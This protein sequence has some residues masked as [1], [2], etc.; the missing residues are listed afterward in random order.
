MLDSI[1]NIENWWNSTDQELIQLKKEMIERVF[2]KVKEKN[3]DDIFL[4]VWKKIV[5][6]YLLDEW[7]TNDK[8]GDFFI[9]MW[10]TFLSTSKSQLKDFREQIKNTNTKEELN[11]LEASIIENLDKQ[12]TSSSNIW[13]VVAWIAAVWAAASHRTSSSRRTFTSSSSSRRRSSRTNT[14]STSTESDDSTIESAQVWEA[15]EVPLNDR[16]RRLFPDWTPTKESDMKRYLT[17]IKVPVV[18][19]DWK[20]KTLSLHIHKK[21][22]NEYTAIFQEMY[23][24]W[25]PVNPETTWW[26]NWRLVRRWKKRSH[27]SYWSAVDVNWDVNGWVYWNTDTNSSYFNGQD[28]VAIWKN[29]WFY[30][31]WD[32]SKRSYDPMHFT[33]MNA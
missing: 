25:I 15:K 26:F 9:W 14:W 3:K 11:T 7:V 13:W 22:A 24:K 32:W 23:D 28:T 6:D 1:D 5:E 16:M 10:L 29:H 4:L 31:W 17:R 8:I 27:H 30:R 12:E 2:D 20:N 21:L 18:T 33:Y 19:P